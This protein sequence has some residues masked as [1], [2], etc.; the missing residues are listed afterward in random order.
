MDLKT[1]CE[2]NALGGREEAVRKAVYDICVDKLGK[3]AVSFDGMGSVIAVR[4]A[5]NAKLPA[6]DVCRAHGRDRPDRG[7]RYRRRADQ[8]PRRRLGRPA[9]AA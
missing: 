6:R 3:D 1:L 9:R 4:K 2:L 8:L 7:L 5:K